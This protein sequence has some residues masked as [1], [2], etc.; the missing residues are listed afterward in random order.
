MGIDPTFNFG[1]F[2]V[3]PVAFRYLLL[4]YRKEGHSPIILGQFLV[5]Q[6]KKFSSYHFFAS[7]LIS[8]CPSLRNIKAFGSDGETKLY[9]AFQMQLPEAT[10]LRCFRHFR[11]NLVSKLTSLGLPSEVIIINT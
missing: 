10:H 6:Q 11:A 2:N 4:E 7:T 9:Q 5:H 1:D 3:T 8:L